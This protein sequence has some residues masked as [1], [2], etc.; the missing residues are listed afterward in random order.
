MNID[1]RPGMPEPGQLWVSNDGRRYIRVHSVDSRYV[2]GE[3]WRDAVGVH[4]RTT[5]ILLTRFRSSIK[6]GFRL[7]P[8]QEAS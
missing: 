7:A 2:H 6:N 1:T 3:A 8:D 4:C 5:R